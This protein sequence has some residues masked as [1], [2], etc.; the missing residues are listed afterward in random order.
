MNEEKGLLLPPSNDQQA[1]S[2]KKMI[3]L[4]GKRYSTA[5]FFINI[6]LQKKIVRAESEI[7]WNNEC[8]VQIFAIVNVGVFGASLPCRIHCGTSDG[9]G[10]HWTCPA[11]F[12]KLDPKSN[13]PLLGYVV[14]EAGKADLFIQP[15]VMSAARNKA[16]LARTGYLQA[17]HEVFEAGL[18]PTA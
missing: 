14:R 17:Q 4:P 12:S 10:D 16:L 7:P 6:G 5:I 1:Q 2:T 15:P 13:L 9:S 11:F 18:V 3:D 8:M